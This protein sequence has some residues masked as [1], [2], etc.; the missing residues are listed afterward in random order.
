MN[1]LRYTSIPPWCLAPTAPAIDATG[2]RYA[3][4]S[5]GLDAADLAATWLTDLGRQA[6]ES[7]R[8]I[9][10][11]DVDGA[12]RRLEPELARATVGWRLL[13]AGPAGACLRIR[14]AALAAG[15]EEDEMV[16]ASI[17]T[18]RNSIHCAHC[19]S[20]TE[21]DATADAGV[22]CHGCGRRLLVHH[23]VARRTGS[24]L[25][26]LADAEGPVR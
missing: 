9:A 20:Y 21:S 15:V 5:V 7:L 8:H 11:D 2:R 13:M 23:H 16:I 6:P 12:L 19:G 17:S 22:E 24:Y 3:V 10:A 18:G 14:A 26:Y 1:R 25:G 4:V